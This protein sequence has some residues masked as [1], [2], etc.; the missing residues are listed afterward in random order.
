MVNTITAAKGPELIIGLVSPVGTDLDIV[1]QALEKVLESFHYDIKPIRLSG[2][3]HQVN[4]YADLADRTF[5]NEGDR[6]KAYIEAGTNLREITGHGDL[7]ALL[8]I[9][10]IRSIRESVN[11]DNAAIPD[12]DMADTPIPRTAFLL[13]SLKHP[14]EIDTSRAVYGKACLIISA[15]STRD[16]RVEALAGKIAKSTHQFSDSPHRAMAEELICLDE[17]EVGKPLGQSV[18][19]AFPLADLFVDVREEQDVEKQIARFMEIFF[20]NTF[21]TPTRDEFGMFHA[22]SAALRSADLA[23]QVGAVITDRDGAI[24]AVGCNDVPKAG[25]GLYWSDDEEDHRDYKLGYDS[26]SRYKRG[27]LS[28]IID[29]LS[30]SGWL[31]EAKKKVDV[32]TMVD[33]MLEGDSREIMRDAQ[34][35]NLIE[36]GRSVHAEMAAI[37][38]AARRG[39]S[40]QDC[41]LFTTTFPCHLCARHIVSAGIKRVVYIEPYPKSMTKK[42]YKDS[43]VVDGRCETGNLV[44]FEPFVGTAP[45]KYLELFEM[46]KRKTSDG[47][48]V[49]W[50][51]SEAEPRINRYVLSYL[52][53]EQ[54][55]VGEDLTEILNQKDLSLLQH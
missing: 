14:E 54:Q 37:T 46:R 3:I 2:L 30:R 39:I 53:I 31:S 45:R 44:T 16:D 48:L 24:V 36:Y 40:I 8:S 1:S 12:S 50:E 6:I 43:I 5:E 38:D 55:L 47:E 15:Y 11:K 22:R 25:G 32:V 20:G 23:R 41:T 10:E 18:S 17:D 13:L 19:E 51:R 33:D 27:I 42:L 52:L 29:R 34:I 4:K 26:S 49:F 9:S 35:M 7:L 21:H 28:E